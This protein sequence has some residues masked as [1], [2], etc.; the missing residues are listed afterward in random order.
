MSRIDWKVLTVFEF[1]QQHKSTAY[2]G[3]H[4]AVLNSCSDLIYFAVEG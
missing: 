2:N 1:E 4:L 3:S